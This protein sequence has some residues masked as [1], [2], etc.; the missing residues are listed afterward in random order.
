MNELNN[1]INHLKNEAQNMIKNLRDYD[2]LI[3][4]TN[5]SELN[6]DG[7]T[8]ESVEPK[9]QRLIKRKVNRKKKN[10]EDSKESE[11]EKDDDKVSK[12]RNKNAN[13]KKISKEKKIEMEFDG[14]ESVSMIKSKKFNLP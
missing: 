7:D 3:K 13:K 1:G 8:E 14:K 2:L 10:N 6:K 12:T 5:N 9:K 11:D 4:A